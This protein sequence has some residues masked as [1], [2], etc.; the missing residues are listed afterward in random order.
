M[1]VQIIM[2]SMANP[3]T[4]PCGPIIYLMNMYPRR[5]TWLTRGHDERRGV[6][7]AF[8]ARHHV[9]LNWYNGFKRHTAN[10]AQKIVPRNFETPT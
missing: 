4:I 3:V 7:A 2:T 9:Q 8:H 6:L 5:G 10:M 1:I